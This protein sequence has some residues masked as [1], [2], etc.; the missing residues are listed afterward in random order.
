VFIR[1]RGERAAQKFETEEEAEL[2][3]AA[4]R[5]AMILGQFDISAM[6]QRREPQEEKPRLTTL[7]EYYDGST[8]RALGQTRREFP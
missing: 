3:A 4:V 8:S 7:S 6:K 2:V 1:Y 5:H